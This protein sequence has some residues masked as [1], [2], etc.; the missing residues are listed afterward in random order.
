[1]TSSGKSSLRSASGRCANEENREPVIQVRAEKP[2]R[3]IASQR[4]MSSGENPNIDL[5]RLVVADALQFAAL[6]KTQQLRL[7]RQRHLA[8]LV[9]KECPA[10]GGL[11]PSRPAVHRAGKGPASVAEELGFQ[12]CFR[13]RRAVERGQRACGCAR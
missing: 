3:G 12:Q 11:D 8:D 2:L 5:Y 1:M 7:Q 13:Y 9:E 4:T 10:I 6:H